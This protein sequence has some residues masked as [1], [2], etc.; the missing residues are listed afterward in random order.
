MGDP[1][2]P[3]SVFSGLRRTPADSVW[4][5]AASHVSGVLWPSHLSVF[6]LNNHRVVFGSCSVFSS[7]MCCAVAPQR[8]GVVREYPSLGENRSV[9]CRSSEQNK[10]LFIYDGG[11]VF[12][13]I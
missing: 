5:F 8:W 4:F 13:I 11:K 3:V 12:L 10:K 1:V 9:L 7:E 2:Q 6:R